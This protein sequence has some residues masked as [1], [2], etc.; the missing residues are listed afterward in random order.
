MCVLVLLSKGSFFYRSRAKDRNTLQMRLRNLAMTR[1]RFGYRRMRV[2]LKR[3]GLGWIVTK[4]SQFICCESAC[5]AL[6]LRG[7]NHQVFPVFL[8]C[9]DQHPPLYF[10][11]YCTEGIPLVAK[12]SSYSHHHGRQGGVANGQDSPDLADQ[13]NTR[14]AEG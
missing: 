5:L 1:V 4:L 9:E 2:L 10:N 13:E 6:E 3:E 14:L 11:S 8:L 7:Q 12:A